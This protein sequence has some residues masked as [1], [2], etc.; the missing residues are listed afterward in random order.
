[1]IK[2]DRGRDEGIRNLQN[3]M[4]RI[5]KSKEIRVLDALIKGGERWFV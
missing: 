4:D 3:L 1:M 2:S 5:F